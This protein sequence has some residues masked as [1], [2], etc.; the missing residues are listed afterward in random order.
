LYACALLHCLT[1][2]GVF[3]NRSLLFV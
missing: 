3:M 1:L 2:V